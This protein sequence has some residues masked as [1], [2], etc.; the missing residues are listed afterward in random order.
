MVLKSSP[1]ET[2]IGRNF[3]F[4]CVGKTVALTLK[5]SAAGG[6]TGAEASVGAA[7]TGAAQGGGDG[8]TTALRPGDGAPQ[9]AAETARG[10]RHIT[11]RDFTKY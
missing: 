1:T 5:G 11:E 7:Q 4:A 10:K 9:E 8:T 2:E 3:V 6:E